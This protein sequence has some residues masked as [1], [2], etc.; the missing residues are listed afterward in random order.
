[1][2]ICWR[3]YH[4]PMGINRIRQV[5]RYWNQPRFGLDLDPDESAKFVLATNQALGAKKTPSTSDDCHVGRQ[6][7]EVIR[8]YGVFRVQPQALK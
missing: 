5:L 4:S 2:Q 8:A 1:M 7:A 3:H 6:A